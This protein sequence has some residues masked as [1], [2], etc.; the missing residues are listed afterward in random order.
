ML[1]KLV[2]K[3]EVKFVWKQYF[4]VDMI[5]INEE[6]NSILGIKIQVVL[7]DSFSI[8]GFCKFFLEEFI[9]NL[10]FFKQDLIKYNVFKNVVRVYYFML[11]YM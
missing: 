5:I 4:Q 7:F 9:F 2:F 3:F 6:S 10:L 11:L 1:L 8:S